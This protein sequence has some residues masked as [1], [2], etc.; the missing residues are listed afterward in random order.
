MAGRARVTTRNSPA[1][2]AGL[3][4]N[5]VLLVVLVGPLGIA[6]AGVALCVSYAVMLILMYALTRDLFAVSFQWARLVQLVVVIGGI[7]VAGEL[8]LP[9]SGAAGF[10]ARLAAW[11]AIPLALAAVRFFRPEELARLR[12]LAARLRPARAT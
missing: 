6:G 12:G 3:V 7:A 8:L 10:V 5:V 1:A 11:A 2:L 9:D 4:V